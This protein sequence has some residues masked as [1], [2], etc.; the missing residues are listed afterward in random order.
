MRKYLYAAAIAIF[1][2]IGSIDQARSEHADN[3][4]VPLGYLNAD[5]KQGGLL[6]DDWVQ[7]KKVEIS[8]R[9]PLYPEYGVIEDSKTWRCKECHGWDYLGDKG[10]YRKGF[11]Y[12]GIKGILNA[13]TKSPQELFDVLTDRSMKHDFTENLYLSYSDVWSL[14]KFIKEGLIDYNSV[15][16]LNGSIKA[17]PENGKKLYARYC[18][19]C[20]GHDGNKVG[21]R[22]LLEGTHGIGW[23]SNGDPQETLHKIRWG[24]LGV[25]SLSMAADN[26]LSDKEALDILSYCQTLFPE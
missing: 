8:K 3:M 9:H 22:E 21:F 6:Y 11:H 14:V 16:D 5:I 7:I 19:D 18:N 15:T 2:L 10:S 20:H 24:H 17:D 12:T 4:Y 26:L 13:R 23:E 25:K 1:L